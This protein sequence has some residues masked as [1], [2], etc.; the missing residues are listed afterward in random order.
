M[1]D[2]WY[3]YLIECEGG[4][5]YTGI[6]P[7]L[8]ARFAKHLA[9]QGALFTKLNKPIRMIAAKPFRNRSEATKAE[10]VMKGLS[11]AHKRFMA[12]S[13]PLQEGLPAEP[14]VDG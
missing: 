2:A 9:G 1:I 10:R 11:A 14:I 3:I 13:W 7:D 12:S 5:L 4:R 8:E 6:T